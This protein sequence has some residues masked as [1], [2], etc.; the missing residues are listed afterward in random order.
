MKNNDVSEIYFRRVETQRVSWPMCAV[1]NG[2]D[3]TL[4]F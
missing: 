2:S 1:S 4:K 3:V